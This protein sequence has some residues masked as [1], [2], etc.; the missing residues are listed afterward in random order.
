MNF[1]DTE[2]DE[3]FERSKNDRA[4]FVGSEIR[5]LIAMIRHL[6]QKLPADTDKSLTDPGDMGFPS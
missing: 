2:L 6:K 3:M 5:V 4:M 1:T